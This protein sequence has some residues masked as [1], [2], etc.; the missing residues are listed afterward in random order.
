M[1]CLSGDEVKYSRRNIPGNIQRVGKNL[2][3]MLLRIFTLQGS[4]YN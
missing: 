2:Q 3:K 4:G 1:L